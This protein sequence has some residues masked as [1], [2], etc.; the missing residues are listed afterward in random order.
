MPF[1]DPY[2]QK[3]HHISKL[4]SYASIIVTY[5]TE[6]K[7]GTKSA[8]MLMET[9]KGV[10]LRWK[11]IINNLLTIVG[12]LVEPI[13]SHAKS[14]DSLESSLSIRQPPWIETSSN[15]VIYPF[16]YE[17]LSFRIMMRS[18]SRSYWSIWYWWSTVESY[19]G[20]SSGRYGVRNRT[21][22]MKCTE[23]RYCLY[24]INLMLL[25]LLLLLLLILATSAWGLS[26]LW[27]G[28]ITTSNI[29]QSAPR[30]RHYCNSL[31]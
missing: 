12:L 20:N 24:F 10:M 7:Y 27:G 1:I 9:N 8:S 26:E 22:K 17:F 3:R 21:G 2:R 31:I 18:N 13:T 6:N 23:S 4:I 14:K 16:L 25:L 15:P 29:Y 28:G 30:L 11:T 5:Q 19:V